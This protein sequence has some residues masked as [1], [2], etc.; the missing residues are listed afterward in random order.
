MKFGQMSIQKISPVADFLQ[1]DICGLDTEQTLNR[2]RKYQSKIPVILQ[3]IGLKGV[4]KTTFLKE[5]GLK[6]IRI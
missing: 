1:L 4:M 2:Y 3:V 6:N 5:R